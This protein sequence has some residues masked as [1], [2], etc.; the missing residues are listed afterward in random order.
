[1]NTSTP[2]TKSQPSTN[3]TS[4]Y[5][6]ADRL[7]FV[8]HI[9]VNACQYVASRTFD[10]FKVEFCT[11]DWK[12]LDGE[13]IAS[14]V[15]AYQRQVQAF[16]RKM[17]GQEGK[18]PTMYKYG[19]NR[20]SGRIYTEQFGVQ[21]LS[22]PLRDM[23]V[24]TQLVD[25]DM[26][27]CHPTLL[28]HL[29][30]CHELPCHYLQEYVS[31]RE[32]TLAKADCTKK[33]VLVMVNKD[34]NRPSDNAW[35]IGFIAE[36]KAL[37]DGLFEQCKN[38]YPQTNPKNPISS[39]INKFLCDFENKILQMVVQKHLSEDDVCVPMFDGFM[40]EQAIDV[41]ELNAATADMGVTW[42]VK[43]WEKATVPAEFE[44]VL[45]QKYGVVKKQFEADHFLVRKPT[46]Y[47]RD[48]EFKTK[49]DFE[50]SAM[51][52]QYYDD[53]GKLK[54]LFPAW[55]RDKTKRAYDGM[56]CT[57]YNPK[58]QDPTPDNILN[59]AVPFK[60]SYIPKATRR[61]DALA[62][63]NYI[64][65]H[66]C[67]SE[68]TKV[69]MRNFFA[70]LL[71]YPNENPQVAPI[72]KGHLGGVGKD[73]IIKLFAA[74]IGN[75][76]VT[77]TDDM[78][79]VFSKF[80]SLLDHKLLVQLNEAEGSQGSKFIGKIKGHVTQTLNVIKEEHIKPRPQKNNARFVGNSN[81]LNPFPYDRRLCLI[82][83]LVHKLI[84]KEWWA[85]FY[86]DKL[87]DQ[88]YLDSLGSDLLDIDLTQVNLMEPPDT[89][90]SL[91]KKS[92][93]VLPIHTVLQKLADGE[94][95]TT[96][97][98]RDLPK[99]EG[100]IGFTKTWLVEQV[101]S[102]CSDA[103]QKAAITKMVE[104]WAVEYPQVVN[105]LGRP[106][107][108]GKQLRLITMDKDK[109]VSALKN[110]SRYVAKEDKEGYAFQ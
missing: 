56:V 42:K 28:L 81:N 62:D 84:P 14:D 26:V 15:R 97:H 5:A 99:Q 75:F 71:Q 80:N 32:A 20:S 108:N 86:A 65:E 79:R 7:R 36:L 83:T 74:L 11:G 29:A 105:L 91:T 39:C 23:L 109:M 90:A 51:E 96:T 33:S 27:N 68:K 66:T 94:Y 41:A 87:T 58:E 88:H 8:E 102:H 17:V 13:V 46:L 48:G 76:W 59:V 10:E 70:H 52:Y 77:S 64:L 6:E 92:Q 98:V 54:D 93:K 53:K 104:S 3:Q 61:D 57:P 18:N 16:C 95:D 4:S 89:T 34:Y 19:K 12:E 106:W 107:V 60:F 30:K 35:V 55:I 43:D 82:Q 31:D 78:E 67:C 40:C 103:P 85:E 37:K 63:F 101:M 47:V 38:K 1:M 22:K 9:D 50:T 73:S 24:P 2:R 110:S 21:R 100:C 45:K 69:F 72:I 44:E 49:Q 25:Y